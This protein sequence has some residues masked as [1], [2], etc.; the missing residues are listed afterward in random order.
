MYKILANTLFLGKKVIYMPSCHST[1]DIGLEMIRKPDIIEGTVIISDEQT[2]GR[3]QRGNAWVSEAGQNLMLSLILQPRFLKPSD[4][5]FLNMAVCLAVRATVVDFLYESK[6]QVK[7]PNDVYIGKSKVA[8]ILIEN[9][10]RGNSIDSAV[11]GIGMNVNQ[12]NFGVL[13]ATSLRNELND[14]LEKQRVFASLITNIEIYYLK[15]KARRLKEI[16]EEYLQYLFGYQT[17]MR[18]KSEYEFLGIIESVD[19]SGLLSI[20]VDG[21]VKKFNFKEIEFIL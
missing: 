4:H 12:K 19:D 6:C 9:S 10:V 13:K 8:G 5:F 21:S 7:W 3:G 1:N 2:K 14:D 20:M 16:K 11:I 17:S 15:L 18:F